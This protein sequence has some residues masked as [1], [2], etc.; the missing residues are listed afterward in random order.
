MKKI[1]SIT[2]LNKT[3]ETGDKKVFL[4]GGEFKFI[5]P[6]HID[7]F[8]YIKEKGGTTVVLVKET[9]SQIPLEERLEIL[10]SIAQ[11]DY[12]ITSGESRMVDKIKQIKNLETI[13]LNKEFELPKEEIPDIKNIEYFRN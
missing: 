2:K 9:E 11:I 1:I 12:I 6:E 4:T 13:I 5:F 3:L 7:L 10:D 8:N